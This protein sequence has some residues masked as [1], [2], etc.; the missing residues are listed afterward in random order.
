[1]VWPGTRE[2]EAFPRG[3][4]LCARAAEE[5]NVDTAPARVPGGYPEGMHLKANWYSAH[6]CIGLAVAFFL[7]FI[8][9]LMPGGVMADSISG[10]IEWTYTNFNNKVTDSSG[11][12]LKTEANNYF[13]RYSLLLDKTI[14]PKLRF[15]LQAIFEK[16]LQKFKIEDQ[17]LTDATNTKFRPYARLT[18][19]DALYTA[20]I[21][22]ALR[23]EKLDTSRLPTI[24]TTQEEYEAILGWK[25][26]GFPT[27][28]ARYTKTNTFDKDRN[29]VDNTKD[30]V[31]VTSQYSYGGFDLRYFGTYTDTKARVAGLDTTETTND[32]RGAYSNSFMNG[33]LQVNASYDYTHNETKATSTGQGGTVN[34]QVFPF[35]GLSVNNDT[36]NLIA[37]APNAALINGNLVASAGINI[38]LPPLG[39]DLRARNIGLDFFNDSDVNSLQVWVDRDLPANIVASF[40]WDIYTSTDNLN[41]IFFRTVSPAPFGAF[42]NRFEIDFQ[43]VRTRY[44]KVVVRPLQAAVVGSNQYPDIFVTEI[45]AFVKQAVS[46][47]S[48]TQKFT[49]D[50]YVG[51]AGLKYRLTDVP[52]LYFDSSYFYLKKDPSGQETWT[53]SNGL[54]INHRLSNIYTVTGRLAFENGVETDDT[55]T[56]W[57]Y[58][59]T[60]LA[61]WL[62]TLTSSMVVSGRNEDVGGLKRTN[63]SVFLNNTAQLYKG[64]DV[65]L[66]GGYT[67]TTEEAGVD[68]NVFLLTAGANVVPHPTFTLT[69]YVSDSWTDRSVSGGPSASTETRTADLTASYNPF[70][71]L[72]LLASL[73]VTDDTGQGGRRTTQN[74]GLNWSPFPDGALQFRFSYNETN[75]PEER[76]NEKIITPGVIYKINNRSFIDVSYQLIKNDTANQKIE[77]NVFTATLKIFL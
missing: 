30:N 61:N 21:G 31:L 27:L 53:L 23:D 58:D 59:A 66:N 8:L 63:N 76:S 35:Q 62:R 69:L 42:E 68:Q 34:L 2:Q 38:G 64:L 19:Q 1:M 71:A 20:G 4:I 60:L 14:Y 5:S 6:Y 29:L 54:S 15:D 50:S 74:Y 67:V 36:P 13:Q 45:Q 51:N 73:Q 49:S 41:W 55:R 44:I 16:D 46:G 32:I 3:S 24:R 37:L 57:V 28:D 70:R 9:V 39:G 47:T 75:R 12:S 48:N 52:L 22:Y 56:A 17:D 18:L 10:N 40:S 33:R 11:Q 7:L 26:V 25:P 43:N 77:S 72:F 65:N